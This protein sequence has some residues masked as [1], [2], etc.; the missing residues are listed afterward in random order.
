M[1]RPGALA[2]AA[3]VLA[4]A[5][6]VRPSR[7]WRRPRARPGSPPRRGTPPTARACHSCAGCPRASRAGSCSRCTASPSTPACSTPWRRTSPVPA[8]RCSP[9]TSAASA[10]PPGAAPGPRRARLVADARAAVRLLRRT[11]PQAPVYLLG[12]SMG[13]SVAMLAVTGPGA[14]APAGTVLLA[15]AVHRPADPALVPGGGPG[16]GGARR[17][18]RAG[19]PELGPR[20]HRRAGHR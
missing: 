20:A 2:L 4:G 1:R 17:A 12:H 9:T 15:P 13:A 7:R 14:V 5:C 16:A 10:A 11:Y 6:S 3:A 8:T 19:A 18:A